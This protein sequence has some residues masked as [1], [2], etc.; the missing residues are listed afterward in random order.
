MKTNDLDVLLAARTSNAILNAAVKSRRDLNVAL[1]ALD[2]LAAWDTAGNEC[3]DLAR[4]ALIKIRGGDC[5]HCGA[6]FVRA[7]RG[8]T[9][10]HTATCRM[11]NGERA[12]NAVGR[13]T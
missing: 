7:E 9:R 5:A 13:S 3:R 8:W 1:S 4:A 10:T 2:D 6:A 12:Q 11:A